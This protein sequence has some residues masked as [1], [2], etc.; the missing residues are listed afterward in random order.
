MKR[1]PLPR[2]A[3]G[4]RWE[5]LALAVDGPARP[6]LRAE[7]ADGRRLVLLQGD[8]V[9]LLARQRVTHH[10]VHYARTG[11][12]T[13]P[14]PPLRAETARTYR[15]ACPDDDAW[16]ARWA[17]HFASALRESANGPLHEGDWHLRPGMSPYAVDAYWET[18]AQHDPDR[19]HIAWFCGSPAHD[20]RDLLPLRPLSTPDA[21]RVKACRRQY[22]EGVLPPVVLWGISALD[23]SVVLDGHDRLA[24]ALAEGGRPPV[25]RL[26]RAG[27]PELHALLAQPDLRA[28]EERIASLQRQR[29]AGD[30]LAPYKIANEGRRLAQLLHEAHSGGH[31]TRG[32]PLPGGS[33]AWE[34]LARRHAPGWHPDTEN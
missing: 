25:L 5:G 33:P 29:D 11:R 6:P 28:Y 7:V 15:E 14:I 26:N 20:S 31:L 10:G 18:L 32:W 16:F 27:L 13:S 30:P 9:V 1:T 34:T 3:E 22:R 17:H 23:T 21:P 2:S 19:G 8:Q 4:V 24:A 12:Y